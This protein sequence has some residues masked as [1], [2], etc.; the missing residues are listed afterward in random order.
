MG[1]GWFAIN[2]AAEQTSQKDHLAEC[3]RFG[4][5]FGNGFQIGN[6][7]TQGEVKLTGEDH[8]GAWLGGALAAYRFDN[9]VF[10]LAEHDPPQFAGPVQ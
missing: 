9:H 5:S 2:G 6:A 8:G 1:K 10:I 3:I 4:C 7:A